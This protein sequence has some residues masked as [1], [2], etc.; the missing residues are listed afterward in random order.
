MH[1]RAGLIVAFGSIGWDPEWG[2][3]V[4]VVIDNHLIIDNKFD[5]HLIIDNKFDNHLIN[6]L[7]ISIIN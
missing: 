2:Y 4:Y 7:V 1:L 6:H 3:G 5:N